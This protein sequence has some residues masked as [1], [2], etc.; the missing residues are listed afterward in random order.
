MSFKEWETR[1]LGDLIEINKKSLS[2]NDNFSEIEYF[3][4]SSVTQNS[5]AEPTVLKVEDAPS[6]AKRLVVDKDIIYSTVRPIQRHFGI[7]R[8]P[9]SNTV[10]STGFAVITCKDIDP[11]FLYYYLSQNNLVEFLNAIAEGSTTTF[12]AFNP[13]LF[14]TLEIKCPPQK[15]QQKIA[16]ILSSLD[17]KIELNRQ[18][19]QTLEAMA[20]ALFTEMCLP[21]G[22]DLPAGWRVEP[23]DDVADFLNGIALQKYP[24]TD[25]DDYL[26]VIKIRE[27]KSGITSS[28]AKASRSVPSKYIIENGDLLF[29]WSATLEV[30]FWCYGEGALNQHLFKVT[31][32]KYPLWFCYML[33]NLH[34]P[35]F[36]KIA[37]DKT[38][39]MGHIQRRH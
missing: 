20:Q 13:S 28:T 27:I 31:S 21:K 36:R 9:K 39:T 24:V 25:E 19:N 14:E 30:M 23:L 38:T 17:D 12:P 10:V 35:N 11:Q 3:D 18:T 5:F 1:V 7:L 37:T 22:E 15:V 6:R 4:T 16:S 32:N 8:N 2:R 34:L 33:I 29:S 26:P